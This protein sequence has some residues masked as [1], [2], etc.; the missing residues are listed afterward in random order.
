MQ[1]PFFGN[2]LLLVCIK[3]CIRMSLLLILICCMD[4][5]FVAENPSSSLV[6]T[7]KPF[8]EAVRILRLAGVKVRGCET[9]LLKL[10]H[11]QKRVARFFKKRGNPFSHPE[12]P[13]S[14]Q[15]SVIFSNKVRVSL[16]IPDL[17]GLWYQT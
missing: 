4:G 5:K 3:P 16:K 14:S 13:K 2:N 6:F 7:Y 12:A 9:F 17:L 10:F 1:T 15:N 11:C 8:L